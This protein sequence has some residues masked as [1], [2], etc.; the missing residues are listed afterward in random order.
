M[1]KLTQR[2]KESVEEGLGSESEEILIQNKG[3]FDH[4]VSTGS[5]L[6]DLCIS[7]GRVDEGGIPGGIILEVF[8]PPSIGKTAVLSEICASAQKRGGKVRFLDPEA[9][10]DEEYS[11][12]YE[13]EL[14]KTDYHRPDTVKQVFDSIFHWDVGASPEKCCHVVA[15]DSLAALSSDTEMSEKGDAMAGRRIAKDF[16]E[17]LRKTCRVIKSNN[18]LIAC[19]NQTRMGDMTETTPGG[20]GIPYYASLRLKMYPAKERFIDKT[21]KFHDKEHKKIIGVRSVCEVVKS[22]VDDP[23]R[24]CE[25]FILF[26]YGI[27]DIRGNLQW[28]KNT[29]NSTTYLAVDREYQSFRDAVSHVEK[30]NL[31]EDLKNR[32]IKEWRELNDCFKEERPRKTR[33]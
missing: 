23:F 3:S 18:W 21:V 12:I 24:K 22:S 13:I 9:R 26:G 17:G 2:A 10:L 14:D 1:A 27:D 16:S 28:L 8:G 30:N 6:L 20:R 4:L 32:V 31:Q 11:R 15:T 33:R 25:I 19:T 5:T 29:L 7:G